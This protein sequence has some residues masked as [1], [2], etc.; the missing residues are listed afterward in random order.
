MT[1]SSMFLQN[2]PLRSKN[3][4][5]T[6]I[7]LLVVISVIGILAGVLLTNFVN[8]RGRGADSRVKGDLRNLKTAL[9]LYYNDFQAYPAS[10][11]GGVLMGCGADG[12]EACTAGGVFSNTT[13]GTV[14]MGQLPADFTYYSDG[15][16]EF[17]LISQLEN[18]SD[19]SI[20]ES[21]TK[22]AATSRTGY[23][24]GTYQTDDYIVCEL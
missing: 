4:G 15:R 6:L 14:Y 21:Q 23:F 2:Q 5:F 16:E 9:R 7:E 22:C 10:G 12:A 13:T 1:L 3:G 20:Q 24:S 19:E 17:L 18:T 8:I 11:T